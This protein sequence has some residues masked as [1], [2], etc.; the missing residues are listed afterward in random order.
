MP[1]LLAAPGWPAPVDAPVDPPGWPA[2]PLA[3]AAETEAAALLLP[4]PGLPALAAGDLLA[5]LPAAAEAEIEWVADGPALLPP[6][7]EIECAPVWPAAPPLSL[8]PNTLVENE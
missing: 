8:R 3:A 2:E 4:A 6:A 7:R 5:A 1:G